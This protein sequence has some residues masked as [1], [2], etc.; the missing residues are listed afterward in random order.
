MLASPV[1]GAQDARSSSHDIPA[2]CA[3]LV[4]NLPADD[5]E[6]ALCPNSSG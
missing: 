5:H 1:F 2:L 6:L 3:P 4:K